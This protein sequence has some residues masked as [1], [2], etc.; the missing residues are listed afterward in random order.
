M[1]Y[2]IVIMRP[3]YESHNSPGGFGC[4]TMILA[5]VGLEFSRS[6]FPENRTWPMESFQHP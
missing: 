3:V 6:S 4:A 1:I 2:E 5:A